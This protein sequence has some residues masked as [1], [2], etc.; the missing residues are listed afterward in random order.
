MATVPTTEQ[1]I[2]HPLDLS[3]KNN[4]AN[5]HMD[6]MTR[7]N[8][9]SALDMSSRAQKRKDQNRCAALSYRKRQRDMASTLE[10]EYEAVRKRNVYLV[11]ECQALERNVQQMKIMLAAR[12]VSSDSSSTLSKPLQPQSSWTLQANTLPTL[13]TNSVFAIPPSS[14]ASLP[15]PL[16][17]SEPAESAAID[18]SLIL[19]AQRPSLQVLLANL[20]PDVSTSVQDPQSEATEAAAP[21]SGHGEFSMPPPAPG[22]FIAEIKREPSEDAMSD[23][24]AKSVHHQEG[25][26]VRAGSSDAGYFSDSY[27]EAQP[28][29]LV[30]VE[31]KSV[32]S[33]SIL[34]GQHHSSS[35]QSAM[36]PPPSSLTQLPLLAVPNQSPAGDKLKLPNPKRRR[37]S[38]SQ[39]P[40]DPRDRKKEQNRRASK[41]FRERKK[42]EMNLGEK[43]LVDLEIRNA[44]LKQ[45]H[46]QLLS[47]IQQLRS[48]L[49]TPTCDS[50][51]SRLSQ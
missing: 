51:E 43:E 33:A 32:P 34:V 21:L 1:Q 26:R 29:S 3:C 4:A 24:L 41:R 35:F 42:E 46:A 28:T 40:T 20:R 10:F 36:G 19:A 37:S 22:S 2:Q 23:Q 48:K 5:G 18:P 25:L 44:S 14:F 8:D 39:L 16:L 12:G 31:Q 17:S 49:L 6:D 30:V 47:A 9:N 38:D 11:G 50:P 45:I 27:S 15:V 7:Q 13:P